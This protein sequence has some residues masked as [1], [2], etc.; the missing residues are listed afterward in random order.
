M[1]ICSKCKPCL[2]TNFHLHKSNAGNW[3]NDY[4]IED[5]SRVYIIEQ[6][7]F[8]LSDNLLQCIINGDTANPL[9]LVHHIQDLQASVTFSDGS[10]Q[11]ALA[12]GDPWTELAWIEITLVGSVDLG[13]RPI[14]RTLTTRFFPRNIL[15]N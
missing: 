10:V 11:T 8:Q 3:L 15:S 1:D 2:S 9:N 12:P 5:N 13:D 7:T 4:D 6:R 14:E